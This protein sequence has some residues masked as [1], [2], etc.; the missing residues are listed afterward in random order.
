MVPQ[1]PSQ[2]CL[3]YGAYWAPTLRNRKF[4]DSP[5]E[6]NGFETSVPRGDRLRFAHDPVCVTLADG[7][8]WIRNLRFNVSASSFV[9]A[10]RSVACEAGDVRAEGK[11]QLEFFSFSC[12]ANHSIE[13]RAGS[14]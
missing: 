14:G 5:L 1:P 8:R 6:G 11:V 2:A 4:A 9:A 12:A 13:P 10:G 7:G 3:G